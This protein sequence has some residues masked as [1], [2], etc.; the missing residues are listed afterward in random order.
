VVPKANK[1]SELGTQFTS[2]GAPVELVAVTTNLTTAP[3]G[4]VA[5]AITGSSGTVISGGISS[6]DSVDARTLIIVTGPMLKGIDS[7]KIKSKKVSKILLNIDHKN[8]KVFKIFS[9]L[10]GA[11]H[12]FVWSVQ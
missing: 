8:I 9:S 1:V 6:S 5:S 10:K 11:E 12:I 2:T 4:P 3:C 7:T